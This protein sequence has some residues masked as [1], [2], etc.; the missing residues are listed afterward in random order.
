MGQPIIEKSTMSANLDKTLDRMYQTIHTAIGK[1]SETMLKTRVDAFTRMVYA[2]YTFIRERLSDGVTPLESVIKDANIVQE[3]ISNALLLPLSDSDKRELDA[4][5]LRILQTIE[6]ATKPEDLKPSPKPKVRRSVSPTAFK[7]LMLRKGRLPGILRTDLENLGKSVASKNQKLINRD[8]REFIGA[9]IQSIYMIQEVISVGIEGEVADSI[10][11]TLGSGIEAGMKLFTPD[12]KEYQE[13][14]DIHN[15]LA[16]TMSGEAS[17]EE[18]E[19]TDY[20]YNGEEEEESSEDP[21]IS[22][23]DDALVKVP[24]TNSFYYHGFKVPKGC[25]LDIW[26]PSSK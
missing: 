11:R 15:K 23:S 4:I 9:C 18:D 19:N 21:E 14:D 17:S 24:H 25:T 7:L 1:E 22:I 6:E 16:H 2:Q 3:H 12:D 20:Y 26:K 8:F 5:N 10:A 13:L